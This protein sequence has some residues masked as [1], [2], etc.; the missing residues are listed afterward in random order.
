MWGD[1]VLCYDSCNKLASSWEMRK[2][3]DQYFERFFPKMIEV[4]LRGESFWK[5]RKYRFELKQTSI[6]N[7]VCVIGGKG[8]FE[9]NGTEWTL[10]PGTIL[11]MAPDEHIVLSSSQEDPLTY[12][13]VHFLYYPIEWEGNQVKLGQYGAPLPF[14]RVF[15]FYADLPELE[16][17][18]KQ[19][20]ELWNDKSTSTEWTVRLHFLTLLKWVSEVLSYKLHHEDETARLIADSMKYIQDHYQSS[21]ERDKLANMASLSSSY[22]SILFKKY[23]GYTPI[24]F[25]NKVRLDKAKQLLRSTSEPISKI[26]RDVG[27]QDPLYFTRLFARE[28]GMAPRM[29]RKS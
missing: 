18:L 24:E 1:A 16:R 15:P 12:Y 22:Y 2:V 17:R 3:H 4:L 21:L 26:A 20:Y 29:Y 10:N 5:Q 25:I 8:T 6:Y 19:L 9:M 14:D 27:Y 7:F 11:H 28:V 13:S 23:S